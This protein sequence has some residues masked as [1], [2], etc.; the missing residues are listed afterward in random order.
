MKTKKLKT[1]EDIKRERAAQ[2]YKTAKAENN[3]SMDLI[4]FENDELGGV[5]FYNYTPE[6][7][8]QKETDEAIARYKKYIAE[9]PRPRIEYQWKIFKVGNQVMY[10]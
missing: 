1:A 9:H 4:E 5:G 7:D 2:V 10:Y 3:S 6:R 8:I